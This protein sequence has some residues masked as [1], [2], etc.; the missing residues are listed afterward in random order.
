LTLQSKSRPYRLFVLPS[1]IR[2]I[3]LLKTARAQHNDTFINVRPALVANLTFTF[4]KHELHVLDHVTGRQPAEHDVIPRESRHVELRVG[5][6]L[7]HSCSMLAT[8]KDLCWK[9]V[10]TYNPMVTRR[11]TSEA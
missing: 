1:Q 10:G 2:N 7:P 8:P 11:H 5:K 6:F 4:L 9:S 3:W